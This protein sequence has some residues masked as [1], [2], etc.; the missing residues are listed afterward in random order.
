MVL[1]AND[2]KMWPVGEMHTSAAALAKIPKRSPASTHE[3]V[4]EAD[5]P[6]TWTCSSRCRTSSASI[7]LLSTMIIM[8]AEFGCSANC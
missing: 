7:C 5:D 4:Q 8:S 1:V 6:L 2:W 3:D